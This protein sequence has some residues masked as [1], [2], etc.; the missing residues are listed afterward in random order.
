ML[1]HLI[2]SSVYE[3]RHT[4]DPRDTSTSVFTD[5]YPR[6]GI[7][8]NENP[9]NMAGKDSTKSFMES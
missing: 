1:V 6:Q 8:P 2:T 7:R 9:H 3:Y 5:E 4:R